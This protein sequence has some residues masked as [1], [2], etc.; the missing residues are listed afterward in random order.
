MLKYYPFLV[1]LISLLFSSC[2]DKNNSHIERDIPIVKVKT[3]KPLIQN[4]QDTVTIYGKIVLRNEAHAASQ[5][6]GRLID[7]TKLPGDKVAKGERIGTVIP[8]EREALLQVTDKVNDSLITLLSDQIQPIPLYSPINGVVLSI[9][10]HTGDLVQ[11][12]EAIMHIGNLNVLD[13]NAELPV[14][15]LD[16]IKKRKYL[17][18]K[19][20]SYPHDDLT[21][22]IKAVSGFVNSSKQTIPIRLELRNNNNKF[23]PGMLVVLYFPA[24]VHKNAITISRNAI[25]DEEGIHSLFILNGN[26]VEKREV[27]VGIYGNDR[28]EIISGISSDDIIVSDKAY[29]ITDGMEVS[30]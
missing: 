5:F 7:F 8:A 27:T 11:K 19:F 9:S 16:M 1:L 13:V 14:K 24:L 17:D 30:E 28:V 26:K 23:H 2:K 6:E 18:M 21:L 3:E 10:K 12:G 4:M 22:P 20:L 25:L 29:S 15:Y